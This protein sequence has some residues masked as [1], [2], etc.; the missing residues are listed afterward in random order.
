[1]LPSEG[2]RRGMRL[3]G[4]D[5]M[6]AHQNVCNV[7][8]RERTKPQLLTART[9]G[10]QQDVGPGRHEHEHR[11]RAGSSRVLSSAFCA[12]GLERVGLGQ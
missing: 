6:L 4:R 2:G 3:L 5:A 11:G 9:H 7:N 8:R 10:W 12:G 1:M